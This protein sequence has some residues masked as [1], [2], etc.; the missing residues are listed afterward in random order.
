[1]PTVNDSIQG[2]LNQVKPLVSSDLQVLHASICKAVPGVQLRFFDGL[3]D[4][5]KVVANP[6]I[7]YGS[8]TLHHAKGATK[9]TFR[10]GLS[11]NT[12]GLSVYVL[13]LCDKQ[14]LKKSLQAQFGKATITGYCI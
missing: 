9:E 8:C 7:G 4:V 2:Y 13:G 11:A 3:N 10:V 6:T 14:F 1:M 12:K 5:G